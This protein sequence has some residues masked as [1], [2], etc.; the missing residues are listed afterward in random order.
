[1]MLLLC[2]AQRHLLVTVLKHTIGFLCIHVSYLGQLITIN[3]DAYYIVTLTCV[4]PYLHYT[5]WPSKNATPMINNFKKTRDR[6]KELCALMHIKFFSQH[7]DTKIINFDEGVLI[8]WPFFWGNVIKKI[9]HFCLKLTIDV[10][11]ISIVWQPRV[12]CLLLLWKTKTAW[13]KRSIHHVTWQCY[14]PGEATQRN[15]SL[16]Q[17]WLLIQKFKQNLKMTLPQK[18]GHRIKTPSSKLTILVSSCWKKNF[19]R[20][21][22]HNFFILSLVFLILLNVSVAFFLGHPVQT[23]YYYYYTLRSSNMPSRSR[24]LVDSL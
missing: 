23:S 22:A 3:K 1:M 9:Y 15:S 10:P 4:C 16:P 19:I 20:N 13:I 8:L 24:P 21:N 17:S 6:M 5:G 11:K 18:N 2:I 7:N 12:K 14:N